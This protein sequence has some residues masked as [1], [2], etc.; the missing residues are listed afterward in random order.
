MT[1]KVGDVVRLHSGGFVMTIIRESTFA[2][3]L[4][5]CVWHDANGQPQAASYREETL[6]SALAT[7]VTGEQVPV[8]SVFNP[9]EDW[10]AKRGL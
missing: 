8:E 9:P 10:R 4:V 7:T 1:F 6:A 3:A 5:E 2:D